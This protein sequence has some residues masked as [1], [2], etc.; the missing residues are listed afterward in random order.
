MMEVKCDSKKRRSRQ[1]K[2]IVVRLL[3]IHA[4]IF[5]LMCDFPCSVSFYGI[6]RSGKRV[7]YV[8]GWFAVLEKHRT[9]ISY[10]YLMH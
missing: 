9:F 2:N 4:D 6:V 3:V 8:F 1:K 10:C 5:Q 7:L